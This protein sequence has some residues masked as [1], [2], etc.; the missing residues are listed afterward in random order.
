[1]ITP[2]MNKLEI[3]K[4][5]WAT[6]QESALVETCV[7]K[8]GKECRRL[9][10]GRV[11]MTRKFFHKE[12]NQTYI[13]CMSQYNG[14]AGSIIVA[15]VDH[16]KQKWYYVISEDLTDTMDAYSA[17]F[18]KRYAER[19]GI[20]YEMP[21][22]I[23][24]FFMENRSMVKIYESEDDLQVAFASRNGVDLC[25]S[26]KERG[27]TKHCTYVSR[28]MLGDSQEEA[29][30]VILGDIDEIDDIQRN[31]TPTHKA[32]MKDIDRHMALNRSWANSTDT[33]SQI[34]CEIYKQYFEDIEE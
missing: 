12:T 30:Q 32:T 17:H 4:Q 13:L 2:S 9:P 20:P 19:E 15:E 18:F 22:I 11:V 33:S 1:M 28:D 26:D 5:M 3:N 29:L 23:T 6:T 31:F 14:V 25:R 10:K 34:A 21:K 8:F 16:G 27:I 7:H 24:R